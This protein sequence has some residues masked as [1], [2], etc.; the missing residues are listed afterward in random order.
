M[1]SIHGLLVY[2]WIPITV[3]EYYLQTE[4]MPSFI[5]FL[6]ICQK[7]IQGLFK[8]FQGPYEAVGDNVLQAT[9]SVPQTYCVGSCQRQSVTASVSQTYCVGSC[10]R[11]SVTASV[12]QTYCVGSCQVDSQTSGSCA[13]QKHKNV[14]PRLKVSNHV[15]PLGYLRR[16]IQPHVG[17]FSMPQK[18]L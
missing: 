15:S 12:S 5:G 17:V 6:P 16:T 3:V 2:S 4:H 11:Q 10:Q 7:Q 1:C 18:L 9:A 13:Q 14:G 8:D